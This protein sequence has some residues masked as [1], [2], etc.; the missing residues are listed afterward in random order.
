MTYLAKVSRRQKSR[1]DEVPDLIW[2][3]SE[4]TQR[5]LAA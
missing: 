3:L 1:G 2:T 5:G 4:N